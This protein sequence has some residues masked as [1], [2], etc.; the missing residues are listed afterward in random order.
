[1]K[2]EINRVIRLWR[3]T[4]F[5]SIVTTVLY[6]AIFGFVLGERVGAVDGVPYAG[7]VSPGLVML[8]LVVNS[9]SNTAFSVFIEKFHRSFDELLCSPLNDHQIIA[10]FVVGG[11]YRGMLCALVVWLTTY[12][13]VGYYL[14]YPVLFVGACL[15]S[16]ILFSLLG[17][18]NALLASSFDDLN[19]MTTL[20]LSPLIMLGGVFYSVNMLPDFWQSVAWL[21]PLLY[22]GNL[23]RYCMIGVAN[24]SP[25]LVTEVLLAMSMV[26]YL[27]AVWLMSKTTYVRQ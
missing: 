10:G 11:I 12:F 27:F 19:I 8:A 4:V 5:P 13:L 6:F 21:N 14:T 18:V 16:S 2:R 26:V 3:Q 23:F 1:M 24:I 9:Y 25:L 17:L 7:F 22:V 15:L 20:L